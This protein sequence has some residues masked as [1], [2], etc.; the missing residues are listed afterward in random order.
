ML[1]QN[2]NIVFDQD[3]DGFGRACGALEGITSSAIICGVNLVYQGS[4]GEWSY[5]AG[6]PDNYEYRDRLL[7]ADGLNYNYLW[8]EDGLEYS[9]L[10]RAWF[11]A[12]NAAIIVLDADDPALYSF[13]LGSTA[14]RFFTLEAVRRYVIEAA[15]YHL[16]V[17]RDN[18]GIGV[19]FDNTEALFYNSAIGDSMLY[20]IQDYIVT[21][22]SHITNSN[23]PYLLHTDGT[24]KR[25]EWHTTNWKDVDTEDGSQYRG[26]C[27]TLARDYQYLFNTLSKTM[28]RVRFIW[29]G[30][31]E[32]Y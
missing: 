26:Y 19:I 29:Q 12:D 14:G 9:T 32:Y 28:S 21:N 20:N 10:R 23:N 11:T 1:D 15:G 18:A 13:Q 6:D 8:T 17:F 27:I 7:A 3:S 24:M 4:G 2:M 16:A 31:D 22:S 30:Q 5:Q 25:Y